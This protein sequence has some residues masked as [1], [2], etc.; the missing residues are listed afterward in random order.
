VRA[1]DEAVRSGEIMSSDV[2]SVR[3]DTPVDEIARLLSEKRISG[4]PVVDD[5]NAPVGVVSELDVISRSGNT[6]ADIMSSG[7]ISVTEDTPAEDIIEILR[8]QRVRRVPVMQHGKLVGII[9]RADLVRLFSVTRWTC[10]ECGYFQ[11]G[12]QRP[13]KC[14]QCGSTSISLQRDPPGM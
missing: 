2:I 13:D 7:V 3:P 8:S 9:S 5:D 4:V 6:A 1:T 11:R 12:F 14:S 10:T